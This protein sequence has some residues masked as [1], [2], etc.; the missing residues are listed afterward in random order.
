MASANYRAVNVLGQYMA[1][2][3]QSGN[4]LSGGLF[5]VIVPGL[6]GPSTITLPCQLGQVVVYP[7]PARL[8]L[9]DT[10]ITFGHSAGMLTPQAYTL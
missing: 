4:V 8:Y 5:L 1:G 9:G 10:W 2:V 6:I 3:S 7:N